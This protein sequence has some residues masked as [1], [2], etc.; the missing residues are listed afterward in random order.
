M[1][2]MQPAPAPGP[3]DWLASGKPGGNGDFNVYLIDRDG[4]KIAAVWGKR[5]EKERTVALL[6]AASEMYTALVAAE[7]FVAAIRD[8][9]TESFTL[10]VI[11]AAIRRAG[12][13]NVP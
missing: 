6:A 11:R 10:G 3:Y 5:G 7:A 4:R 8:N 13:V 12:E 9:N 1:T 2:G